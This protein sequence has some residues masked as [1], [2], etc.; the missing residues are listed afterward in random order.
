MVKL[1]HSYEVVNAARV[2][3]RVISTQHELHLCQEKEILTKMN[4]GKL[5][6]VFPQTVYIYIYIYMY[7]YIQ[8]KP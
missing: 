5:G 7:I 1:S 4:S 8:I 2:L 6:V 3:S